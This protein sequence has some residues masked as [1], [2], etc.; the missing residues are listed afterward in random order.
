[1]TPP[2]PKFGGVKETKQQSGR[3]YGGQ[4]LPGVVFTKGCE[5]LFV[6][7][8]EWFGGGVQAGGEGW[9]PIRNEG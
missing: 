1:M 4:L 2:V 6:F 5:L 3:N 8:R 9:L 7:L